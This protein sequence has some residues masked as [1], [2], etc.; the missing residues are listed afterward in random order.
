[1]DMVPDTTAARALAITEGGR[2]FVF[3][4]SLDRREVR[5]VNHLVYVHVWSRTDELVDG[6]RRKLDDRVLLEVGA[7]VPEGTI[8]L[9]RDIPPRRK[10]RG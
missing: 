1:M 10:G 7:E 3:L 2:T 5:G 6:V 9:L 8:Q 4:P